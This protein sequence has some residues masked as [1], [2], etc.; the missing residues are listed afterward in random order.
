MRQVKT[1][2]LVVDGH[3]RPSRRRNTAG[4]YRVGAKTEKEAIEIL[5][6][7]IGFGSIICTGEAVDWNTPENKKA[8]FTPMTEKMPWDA[9]VMRR[10]GSRLPKMGYKMAMRQIGGALYPIEHAS[11]PRARD[12]L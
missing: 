3:R 4:T 7:A 10:P 11:S 9:A 5:R 12:Y 8:L 1:F 6:K 2:I